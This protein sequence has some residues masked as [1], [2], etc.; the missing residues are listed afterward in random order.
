M[1]KCPKCGIICL[2]PFCEWCGPFEDS[3]ENQ[4]QMDP[5]EKI[6][7]DGWGQLKSATPP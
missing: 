4:R 3:P 1:Y 2:E 6:S 7:F 5:I